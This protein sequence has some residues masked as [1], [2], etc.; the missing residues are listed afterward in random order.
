MIRLQRLGVVG[1]VVRSPLFDPSILG[2]RLWADF[3]VRGGVFG[4]RVG[5]C[6]FACGVFGGRVGCCVFACGVF[7]GGVAA[8]PRGRR[9]RRRRYF[10]LWPFFLFSWR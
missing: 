8:R 10:F 7:G 1:R 5:C 6:V 4:G 9:Q 2:R 3:C